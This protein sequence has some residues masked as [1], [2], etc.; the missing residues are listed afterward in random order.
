MQICR[1]SADGPIGVDHGFKQKIGFKNF[2][3]SISSM[4]A[5][6][7]S[8][9]CSC[10]FEFSEARVAHLQRKCSVFSSLFCVNWNPIRGK[11]NSCTLTRTLFHVFSSS[12]ARSQ[13]ISLH[14]KQSCETENKSSMEEFFPGLFH[15]SF[16][17]TKLPELI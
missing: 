5:R 10:G 14:P 3:F 2:E 17:Q 7:W 6:C 11:G 15:F 13:W 9:P 4:Q 8:R 1:N 16:L 12:T